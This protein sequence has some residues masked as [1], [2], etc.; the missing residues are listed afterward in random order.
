MPSH[1]ECTGQRC[2]AVHS[3]AGCN[4]FTFAL[5]LITI[6]L[7]NMAGFQNLNYSDQRIFRTSG[8][9]FMSHT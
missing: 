2:H 4:N 7:L 3:P 1:A 6:G 8:S 5:R 9:T